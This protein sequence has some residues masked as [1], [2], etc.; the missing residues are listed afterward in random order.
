MLYNAKHINLKS[1]IVIF[2]PAQVQSVFTK[3]VYK[4]HKERAQMEC[5]ASQP[6]KPIPLFHRINSCSH[7]S[8]LSALLF[9]LQPEKDEQVQPQLNHLRVAVVNSKVAECVMITNFFYDLAG[10]VD[11]KMKILPQTNKFS[12]LPSLF[13]CTIQLFALHI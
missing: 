8:L 4:R 9:S 7:P 1:P 13:F 2:C 11:Y 5:P 3:F 10:E 6:S 12:F